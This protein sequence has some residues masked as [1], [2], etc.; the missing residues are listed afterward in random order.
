[1]FAPDYSPWGDIQYDDELYTG[2]HM[3]STASHGGIMILREIVA[4]LLDKDVQEYG[5]WFGG[6]LCFEEDCDAPI[7]I[8]EL[9]DAGL[10]TAPVNDYFKP[11]EYED[12]VN[13]S[14]QTWHPEY[15]NK[16]SYRHGVQISAIES[17]V[18]A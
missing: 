5:F 13:R 1:M 17:E 9:L 4:N 7:A 16:R 2:V 10:Y 11:G 6:Y 8:R 12:C 15:W 14:L 3:V 18:I